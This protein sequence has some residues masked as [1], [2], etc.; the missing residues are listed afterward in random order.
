ME[1]LINI[2]NKNINKNI[3]HDAICATTELRKENSLMDFLKIRHI[4]YRL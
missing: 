4:V 1:M 3:L 2:Q